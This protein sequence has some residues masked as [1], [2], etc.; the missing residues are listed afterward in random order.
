MHSVLPSLWVPMICQQRGTTTYRVR[1]NGPLK[2]QSCRGHLP[3]RRGER[4]P[5]PM[6]DL[7][8]A[9]SH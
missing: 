4:Q 3:D 6:L 5:V 1:S 7:R 2:G 8:G 9:R